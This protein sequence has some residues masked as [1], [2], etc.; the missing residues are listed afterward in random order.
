MNGAPDFGEIDLGHDAQVENVHRFVGR[1]HGLSA[2]IETH[3]GARLAG[4]GPPHRFGDVGVDG[5]RCGVFQVGVTVAEQ[6][7][8]AI[9]FFPGQGE[10]AGAAEPLELAVGLAN[11]AQ[12]GL[13]PGAVEIGAG[14]AAV[15]PAHRLDDPGPALGGFGEPGSLLF[16]GGVVERDDGDAG[17][18]RHDDRQ[19]DDEE[20]NSIPCPHDT[21]MKRNDVRKNILLLSFFTVCFTGRVSASFSFP[22]LHRRRCCGSSPRGAIISALLRGSGPGGAA[23]AFPAG[24]QPEAGA[25]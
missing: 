19:D 21:A 24:G 17:D 9:V 11:L 10:F 12:G 5:N 25:P 7:D 8:D 13:G 4:E 18:R 2:V 22:D 15:E 3:Q 6:E 16:H 14:I 1:E 23:P 20:Q